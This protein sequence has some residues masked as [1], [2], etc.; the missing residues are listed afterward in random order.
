MLK[1]LVEGYERSVIDGFNVGNRSLRPIWVPTVE[2][3]IDGS[4]DG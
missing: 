1:G 2:G 3:F 4:L